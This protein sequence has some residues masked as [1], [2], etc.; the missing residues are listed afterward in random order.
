[1]FSKLTGREK[2]LLYVLLCLSILAGGLCLLIFPSIAS[3][4]EA[5]DSLNEIYTQQE[6]MKAAVNGLEKNQSLA[7]ELEETAS[8][9]YGELFT[10][11]ATPEELDS[12]VT[13]IAH[14]AGVSPTTLVISN[15]EEKQAKAYRDSTEAPQEPGA[16]G[17][18]YTV[19]ELTVSGSCGY[20]TF[21]KLVD[22]YQ[23]HK[24]LLISN[25]SFQ[26]GQEGES[27]T[28]VLNAYLLPPRGTAVSAGAAE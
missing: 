17:T 28:I 8:G 26:R 20:D 1:M 12:F 27:F 21:V 13:S 14:G 2:K 19:A 3:N 22:A 18:S 7:S 10:T 15:V 9:L 11:K 5:G 24:Q 23:N 4:A 25:A 16:E 6:Q